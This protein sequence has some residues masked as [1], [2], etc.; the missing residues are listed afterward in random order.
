MSSAARAGRRI[1]SILRAVG[2]GLMIGILASI[3]M[4][5]VAA[6]VVPTAT[7]STAL[8]VMTSSMAPDLPAGT[9]VVVRPAPVSEIA[10]GDVLTYQLR[11]G[12][13]AV[14]TH[15]VIEQHRTADGSYRFVTKGDA[16]PTADPDFVRE[17]QVRGVLWY[18][19][20]WVGWVTQVVTGEVK[21]FVVPL[22]VAALLVYALW[23]FAGALRERARRARSGTSD[24]ATGRSDEVEH[25][26]KS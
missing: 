26:Q 13:P 11:S 18:S 22:V 16:N 4:I 24:A 17:E 15:R 14:V 7:G 12:E 3:V 2:T 8:T 1:G 23:M 21:A 25:A 19:I 9:L 20:P 10:P 5:A 6:I